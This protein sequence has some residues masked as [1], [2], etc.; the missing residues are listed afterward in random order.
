M[1][2][3]HFSDFCNSVGVFVSRKI[4]SDDY[5][6]LGVRASRVALALLHT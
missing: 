5:M 2:L 4:L 1:N 3:S 6:E